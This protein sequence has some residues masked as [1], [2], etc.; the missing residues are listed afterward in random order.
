MMTPDFIDKEGAMREKKAASDRVFFV[1]YNNLF[2][3]LYKNLKE[4]H[5]I[6]KPILGSLDYRSFYLYLV[7]ESGYKMSET[8][9]FSRSYRAQA[10]IFRVS[11]MMAC[12]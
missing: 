1:M 9:I 6:K 7:A 11:N 5:I 10:Y 8:K 3:A 4:K 12:S 2:S